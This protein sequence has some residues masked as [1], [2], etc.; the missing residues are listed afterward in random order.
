LLQTVDVGE[1]SL[2]SYEGV[3][4][5]AILDELRSTAA[6][7]RGT[8]VLHVNA[9]PYGGG[10]SEL[11]RS[12]VPLLNDLGILADWK[13]ISGNSNFFE[14]TKKIHN[15]LQGADLKLTA[16][17]KSRYEET[18]RANSLALTEEYDVVFV[19]DP[20]PAPIQAFHRGGHARW[21]WR[22][23]IDTGQPNPEVWRYCRSFLG[24]YDA[25]IFTMAA[26]VPPDFPL[27][28]IEVMPPAID[29]L[30]P[31]NMPVPDSMARQ[32]LDWIG[33]SVDRPLITQVSRFDS[34]KDPLGVIAAYKL[35]RQEIPGLQLALVGSMAL[36]DP[37]G[38]VIYRQVEEASASDP[39][40][41]VFTN[42]TGVG[43]IEVNAF[44][45]L[46]DVVVQ[47]S[48]REGFGLVVSES[49]WKATPVVAGNAGGIPLQMSDGVGG[50]LVDG[51]EECAGAVLALL[52]EPERARRLAERGRERVRQ[53]FLL[54][55]LLLNEL[56]LVS[57]LLQGR[58]PARRGAD[59]HRDPVCGMALTG[60]ETALR[61]SY[62]GTEHLFCSDLC[63][64]RFNIEPERYLQRMN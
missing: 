24:G 14:V 6:S 53:H 36:D 58:P 33:I 48:I 21:V 26:F 44:Q 45:R 17:E 40:I 49:L 55:R 18:A 63:R 28:R 60:A 32:I 35:V 47:K 34:W 39:L 64:S 23:H 13:I 19:H 10:V 30:S 59:E 51:I 4:P 42:L 57:S 12:T 56:S 3:V 5:Q 8:R 20:Q 37:E 16:S 38:W 52:R 61:A 54:P 2:A 27:G 43:N 22:C 41:H 29:P 25:A 15:G 62:N 7:L 1:R 11:L 50:L 9:T 46:S 31:K